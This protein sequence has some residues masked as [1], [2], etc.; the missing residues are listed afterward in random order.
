MDRTDLVYAIKEGMKDP[1][2][3]KFLQD[4]LV[5]PMIEEQNLR[6]N[7]I[8]QH[9]RKSNITISGLPEHSEESV[10]GLVIELARILDVNLSPG[11]IVAAHRIGRKSEQSRKHRPVIVRFVTYAKRDELYQ[12]RKNL[13]DVVLPRDSALTQSMVENVY[14]S[15]NLTRYNSALLFACREL[16]R[17]GKLTAAWSDSGRIKVKVNNGPT[18]PIRSAADLRGLVGDHPALDAADDILHGRQSSLVAPHLRDARIA[19]DR[20]SEHGRPPAAAEHSPRHQDSEAAQQTR[21]SPEAQSSPPSE[22][23]T[24]SVF[25][26]GGSTRPG[27]SGSAAAQRQSP[28]IGPSPGTGRQENQGGRRGRSGKSRK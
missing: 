24:P 15:D 6:I 2:V 12:E 5:T 16:K 26:P 17:A 4:Q 18:K 13:R 27:G 28:P 25:R 21:G 11:E 19:H 20:P 9:S 7:D 22:P 1:V 10:M 3:L 8:E 14:I 23:A